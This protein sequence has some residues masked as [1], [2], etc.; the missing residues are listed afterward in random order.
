LTE[1]IILLD[2]PEGQTSFQALGFLKRRLGTGRIGHAGTLDK[3]AEGLLIV[4]VGR[5]TRLCSLA[6]SLDK[7]Y[8]ADLTFG[9]GTDTLD[10]EGAVTAV[11][12][13][14]SPGEIEAVL[15]EFRGSLTQVP[16]AY[17]A[18][19]VNGR[20]ASDVARSGKA[21]QLRPRPVRID[22]LE[23]LEYRPPEASFRISCSKGTYIRSL[24]RDIAARLGTFAH[25]SRLRRIRIGGFSVENAR[26]PEAFDPARDVLS[27]A[28]FF[29][30]VPELG[31]LAV[32]QQWTVPVSRGIKLESTLFENAPAGEATFGAFSP[33]QRLLAV[34]EVSRTGMRYLATFPD[35]AAAEPR[36]TGAAAEPRITGAAV[37]PRITG[38][39]AEPPA[40]KPG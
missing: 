29:S 1:G 17:S 30:A 35:R 27:P 3:F 38:A 9:R 22:R 13:I 28:V 7:E 33:D 4:L 39:A 15:P 19:H 40:G 31:K 6:T 23:M 37:E 2:K 18:V 24:A 10:P 36:I 32:K 20:R 25:V 34:I 5:M 16:P 11:G 21:V 12:R 8:L 14:P 26:S